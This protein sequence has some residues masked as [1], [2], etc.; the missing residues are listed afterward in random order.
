MPNLAFDNVGLSVC[1]SVIL[2]YVYRIKSRPVVCISDYK[3]LPVFAQSLTCSLLAGYKDWEERGERPSLI[4][5]RQVLIISALASLSTAQLCF[6]ALEVAG[7]CTAGTDLGAR[8]M[9]ALYQCD[10]GYYGYTRKEEGD[11]D[12]HTVLNRRALERQTDNCHSVQD[13]ENDFHMY[14]SCK[15]LSHPVSHNVSHNP[16]RRTVCLGEHRVVQP[17]QYRLDRLQPVPGGH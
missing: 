3:V 13:I 1:C 15:Y 16:P 8:V 4:M 9:S 2:L 5:M 10:T 12:W 11:Q 17:L 14:A 7:A 6:D